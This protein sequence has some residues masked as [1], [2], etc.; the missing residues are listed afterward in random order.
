MRRFFPL[1]LVAV[2]LMLFT[3]AC[4]EQEEAKRPDPR[5]L[6]IGKVRQS[7]N[8]LKARED[9]LRAKVTELKNQI[10]VNQE[11][12]Q[13][14]LVALESSLESVSGKRDSIQRAL[15]MMEHVDEPVSAKERETEKGWPW[16]IKLLLLVALVVVV[17]LVIRMVT[18]DDD[19]E[20]ADLL[21]DEFLE[22]NELGTVRYPGGAGPSSG[23]ASPSAEP[24]DEKPE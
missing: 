5:E 2:F 20:D 3:V 22:E 10:R 8:D 19:L 13:Q 9:D 23:P 4:D 15:Q 17:F 7:L 1:A 11:N 18:R 24:R 21:D 16:P 6:Q 12:V 14:A